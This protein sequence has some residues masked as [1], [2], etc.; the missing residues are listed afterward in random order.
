MVIRHA[1]AQTGIPYRHAAVAQETAPFGAFDWASTKEFAKVS[2]GKTK[3]PL[4]SWKIERLVLRCA[5]CP[6]AVFFRRRKSS[7]L[8][9]RYRDN[10]CAPV[11]RANILADI[12][13]ENMIPHRLAELFPDGAS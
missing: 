10:R 5:R 13:P 8:E 12:A 7:W 1:R 3:E 4:Q 2:L 11:P 6:G 9:L